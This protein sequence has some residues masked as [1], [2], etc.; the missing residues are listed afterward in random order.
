MPKTLDKTPIHDWAKYV[1]LYHNLLP[2]II[3]KGQPLEDAQGRKKA[4]D[5]FLIRQY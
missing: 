4:F 3:G 5:V 1:V 2:K